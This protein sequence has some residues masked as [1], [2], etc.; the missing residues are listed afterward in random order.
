MLKLRDWAFFIGWYGFSVLVGL[1]LWGKDGYV[2]VCWLGVVEVDDEGED[3]GAGESGGGC[4]EEWGGGEPGVPGVCGG[5]NRN[6]GFDGLLDE[7]DDLA[8]VG[9]VGQM[10]EG[11]RPLMGRECV[12][13]EGVELV[14]IQMVGG[15]G[16]LGHLSWLVGCW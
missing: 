2:G 4:A 6:F 16:V 1:G 13:D 9:A 12:L 3:D 10:R 11:G 8:A 7:E 15:L 5:W 14:G